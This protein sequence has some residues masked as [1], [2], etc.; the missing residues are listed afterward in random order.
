MLLM[1]AAVNNML[2]RVDIILNASVSIMLAVGGYGVLKRKDWGP[3]VGYFLSLATVLFAAYEAAMFYYVYPSVLGI[4]AQELLSV[5]SRYLL[6]LVIVCV[7]AFSLSRKLRKS[8]KELA[9]E[10]KEVK[11]AV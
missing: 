8:A 11:R 3:S 6:P 4:P 7:A 9:A 10:R 1:L 2:V 5:A